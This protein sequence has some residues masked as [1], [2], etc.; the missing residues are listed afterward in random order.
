M[1]IQTNLF[2]FDFICVDS[3]NPIL[4]VYCDVRK[5]QEPNQQQAVQKKMRA[6]LDASI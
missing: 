6:S 4:Y 2:R 5:E 1:K 3:G